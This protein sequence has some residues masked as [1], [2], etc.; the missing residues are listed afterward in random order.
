MTNA[1]FTRRR[2][3]P[4]PVLDAFKYEIASELGLLERL[5]ATDWGQLTSQECGAVGG[6]MGGRMVRVMVRRAERDLLRQGEA[7]PAP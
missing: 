3:L 4:G 1:G 7:T 6:R 5:E 2:L